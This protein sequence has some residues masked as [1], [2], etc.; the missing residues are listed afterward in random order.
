[1]YY[2]GHSKQYALIG[3]YTC[4]LHTCVAFMLFACMCACMSASTGFGDRQGHMRLLPPS[5]H[6]VAVVVPMRNRLQHARIFHKAM[7]KYQLTHPA[8][9]LSMYYVEQTTLGKGERFNRAMMFNFGLVRALN[10]TDGF[11][12]IVIHD[13]DRVPI[14]DVP[15]ADCNMPTHLLN[16]VPYHGYVGGVFGASPAH[17]TSINGMSNKFVGWGGEDDELYQ[18]LRAAGLTPI[19]RPPKDHARFRHLD[20][21]NHTK[22]HAVHYKANVALLRAA[23]RQTTLDWTTHDGFSTL[24]PAMWKSHVK[25]IQPA[26]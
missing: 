2:R 18:R 25:S 26:P 14:S 23:E 11:D 13:I 12:C 15:Y 16:E 3:R 5:P 24:T 4:C 20:D 1:M 21:E 10:D 6:R 17:W 19:H 9:A 22:R 8:S 7:L